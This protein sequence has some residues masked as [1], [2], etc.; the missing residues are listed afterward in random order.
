VSERGAVHRLPIQVRF[1]DTDMF[2][3]V[4]NA[5]FATY[6][7]LGR[8]RFL[9]SLAFEPGGLI[10]ARIALDFRRQLR[11]GDEAELETRVTRVGTTSLALEQHLLTGGAVAC[12]VASVVVFFDY[13]AQRPMP[14]PER[15]RAVLDTYRR[16]DGG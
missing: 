12:E 6:A 4:N 1:G 10:L 14:V 2:G 9:S 8:L 5:A 11:Y 3:H 16:R 7:E 13:A 15:L